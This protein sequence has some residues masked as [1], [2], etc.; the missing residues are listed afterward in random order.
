[1]TASGE[2]R[3]I[4]TPVV[5]SKGSLPA[6]PVELT[7]IL[8]FVIAIVTDCFAG[9]VNPVKGLSSI[10]VLP[11]FLIPAQKDLVLGLSRT[12]TESDNIQ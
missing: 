11:Y 10:P 1:V 6:E 8:I 5:N 9:P 2:W 4:G 3:V 12:Q 7:A